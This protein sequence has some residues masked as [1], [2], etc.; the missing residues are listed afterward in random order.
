MGEVREDARRMGE[1]LSRHGGRVQ[2]R[3][4]QARSPVHSGVR[5]RFATA[6]AS[7]RRSQCALCVR[8]G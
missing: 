2:A 7:N 6:T 8:R 4:M 1:G 3:Q 5:H